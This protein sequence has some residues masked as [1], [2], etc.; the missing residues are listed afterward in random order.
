MDPYFIAKWMH[1]LSATLLFGTGIGTAFQMVW[2]MRTRRA[3]TVATVAGGVVLADWLFTVPAG[4][5]Q[6]LTGIWLVLLQGHPLSAPWL[7]L[8]L[9]LY[10][11]AFACWAPVAM[12]QIR[13]RNLAARAARDGA[14]LPKAAIRAYRIWII[15]GWPAF[16]ALVVVFWLMVAKPALW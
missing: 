15:L 3:Q 4:L 12:L 2:A 6:P 7:L 8:S 9:A 16:T 5:I 14:S 11:L 10:V 13:I 1:I